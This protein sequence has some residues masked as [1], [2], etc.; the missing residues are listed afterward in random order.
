MTQNIDGLHQAA[1]STLVLELHGTIRDATCLSCGHRTPMQEQLD[2]V[3]AGDLDP[4]CTECGGIQKSATIAFGQQ[5]DPAVL[6]LAF[7]HSSAC[8][9]FLA[10]GTSLAVQPAASLAAQA[11]REGARLVIVNQ[12][13]TSLDDLADAKLQGPIGEVL[14]RLVPAG[15]GG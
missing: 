6:Q 8:D 12:G 11:T 3:R 4:A 5:L 9:L 1:G 2:R 7:A 10:I 13:E 14:P 15:D